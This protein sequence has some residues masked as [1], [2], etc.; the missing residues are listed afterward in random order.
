VGNVRVFPNN[1]NLDLGGCYERLWSAC[2]LQ[3]ST[4]INVY[5]LQ[6]W[7]YCYLVGCYTAVLSYR[8][9]GIFPCLI[10][11]QNLGIH[12]QDHVPDA[13]VLRRVRCNSVKATL[14]LMRLRWSG[15]NYFQ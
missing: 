9:S 6:C 8:S 12:W 4:K 15:H 11:L 2:G 5:K 1:Q 14:A 7:Q 3:L 10:P 13:E